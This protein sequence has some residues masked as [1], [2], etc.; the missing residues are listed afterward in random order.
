MSNTK[1]RNHFW[2]YIPYGLASITGFGFG[3]KF[4]YDISGTGLA[5]LTGFVTAIICNFMM[6]YVA[7]KIF[8]PR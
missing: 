2:R 7:L 5:I 6:E 3:F 8:G 4:G 1:K